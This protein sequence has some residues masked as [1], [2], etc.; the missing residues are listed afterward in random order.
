MTSV[1]YTTHRFFLIID[2]VFVSRYN[3]YCVIKRHVV[4]YC[5]A[6]KGGFKVNLF[7]HK[8][9]VLS[10]IIAL[11]VIFIFSLALL[12][13]VHSQ[14][15]NIPIAVVNEDQGAQVPNQPKLT[16]GENIVKK[17]QKTS[18]KDKDPVVRWINVNSVKQAE[19]GLDEQKYYA[20]LILPQDF[21]IKQVSLQTPAPSSPEVK[22]MINEG[23]NMAA[24]T[25]SGQIL[26]GVVDH[27]NDTV[28]L[29]LLKGYE[30]KGDQLTV[31]QATALASPIAKKVISV[32]EVGP[33][34]AN[35]NAPVS[36]F[37]PLWMASLASAAIIFIAV[38]KRFNRNRKEN[39]Y[40]KISQIVIGAVISLFVGFGFTWLADHMIGLDIPQF[41]DT[42]LFLAITCFSFY[43]L[44]SAVLS[45]L[46]LKGIPIFALLLFFGAPLLALAPEMM[47]PF[48]QD[49]VY[50]WLPMRFM[51]AG[52]RNQFFFGE[53]LTWSG[54]VSVLVWIGIV[55]M[56]M[57]LVTALR[58]GAS[59]GKANIKIEEA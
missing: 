53:G 22:I 38:R 10:P 28:R 16:L 12:P 41:M 7:K 43:L 44:I 27:M 2:K 3:F 34:S 49:W 8:L 52:L 15:K 26:N 35:G 55:S 33:H 45:L 58:S 19:K 56:F 25:L 40:N 6:K 32:H 46:G 36:L 29:Q 54:P 14:P 50:P 47:S 57:I 24:S 31:E 23:M 42:A 48:Y 59:K 21:S 11:A 13:S 4:H 5:N 39:I 30:A 17:I 20:A 37:Q 18:E 51:V 1:V 9:V